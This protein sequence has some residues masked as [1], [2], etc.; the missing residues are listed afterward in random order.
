M[1]RRFRQ[2]LSIQSIKNP[3]QIILLTIVV[4]NIAMIIVGSVGIK[5]LSLSGTEAMSFLQAVFC[6]ISMMLDPGC[7]SFVVEDVGESG[8]IIAMVC[9]VIVV[10]GMISF[11]GAVIGYVTNYIATII[12]ES[13]SSAKAI[14]VSDHM[15]ILNWNN[16]AAEIINDLLYADGQQT[17]VV[18]VPEGKDQIKRQIDEKLS[19]TIAQANQGLSARAA[20]N[21]R[22]SATKL[23]N[24]LT[25]IVREGDVFS[26]KQLTDIAIEKAKT[27]IILGDDDIQAAQAKVMQKHGN[28]RTVKTLMQVADLTGA[29]SSRDDQNIIVEITDDWTMKQ[30]SQII[31]FKQVHGKC[32]ITP[33][34][35]NT[36]LG[37]ILSQF[38]VIPELN[39]VYSEL[40]SN[41]GASIYATPEGTVNESAISEFM[42]SHCYAIPLTSSDTVARTSCYFVASSEAD[43]LR[44]CKYTDCTLSVQVNPTIFY[45][46]RT[47]IIIGRNS[48]Y[49]ELMDGYRAYLEEWPGSAEVIILDSAEHLTDAFDR[50]AYPFISEIIPVNSFDSDA[51]PGTLRRLLSE[52]AN[53]VSILILSDDQVDDDDTDADALSNLIFVQTEV[54]RYQKSHTAENRRIDVIVELVD[55]R[56]HDIVTSYHVDNV[57]ISNRYISKLVTQIGEKEALYAFFNDILTYDTKDVPSYTS[58]EIYVRSAAAFFTELPPKA[59]AHELVRAVIQA[60]GNTSHSI[61]MGYIREDHEVVLFCDDLTECEVSL[62][63]DDKLILFSVHI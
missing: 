27:I 7:I 53:D 55:P 11:T 33:I 25:V 61:L 57:V 45:P 60:E 40:F 6:T 20:Q 41:Y 13:D 2:W 30:V 1:L 42:G 23:K 26:L 35:I 8:V 54:S 4:V 3:R 37:Q 36:V 43:L 15:I 28:V 10:F 52:K 48:K 22:A 18:L 31:D 12:E 56:H 44:T 29:A 9:F 49:R 19:A 50:C 46:M 14:H 16:R 17:V 5:G 34:N 39:S 24:N 47:I 58:K 38:T 51:I 62:R 59:S 63:P 21:R 32:N